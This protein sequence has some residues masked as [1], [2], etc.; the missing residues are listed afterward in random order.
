MK[1]NS[2]IVT[3]S[4]LSDVTLSQILEECG[5]RAEQYD[6]A[7]GCEEKKVSML[8]KRKPCE[9]NIGPYN[10]VILKLLKSNMQC[11]HT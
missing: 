5:V 7:R 1:K 9:V 10:R 3:I 11:F 6:N 2:Y 8:Y 4:D